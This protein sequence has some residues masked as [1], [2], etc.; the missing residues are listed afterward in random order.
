MPFLSCGW[1]RFYNLVADQVC[2]ALR[3]S[4]KILGA[5]SSNIEAAASFVACFDRFLDLDEAD[6]LT[7]LLLLQLLL[8]L[9]VLAFGVAKMSSE[10]RE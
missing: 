3:G 8:P 10:K 9:V 2:I 5:L 6:F 1:A 4:S 7:L